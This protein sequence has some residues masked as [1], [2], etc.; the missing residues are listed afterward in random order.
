MNKYRV[1]Y[2]RSAVYSAVGNM[3][4]IS[5]V[6]AA[7]PGVIHSGVYTAEQLFELYNQLY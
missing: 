4:V 5:K 6:G 1:E 3:D 7:Q 2:S